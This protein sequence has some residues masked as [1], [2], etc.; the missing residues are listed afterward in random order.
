M[1][2]NSKLKLFLTRKSIICFWVLIFGLMLYLPKYLTFRTANSSI[3]ILVWPGILDLKLITEFEKSSGI[4]VNLS[5]FESNDELISKLRVTKGIGYD[6]I[7][8]SDYSV[9]R[10]IKNNILKPLD[11]TKLNFWSRL[12][13]ALLDHYFDP[14]NSFTVPIS[15]DILGLGINKN[16][17]IISDSENSSWKYVFD[18]KFIPASKIVISD[19]PLDVI[20]VAAIYLFGSPKDIDEQKLKHI[21]QLLIA[22]KPFVE[23]YTEYRPDYYLVTKNASIALESSIYIWRSLKDYPELDFLI[24]KE[25][26]L[27]I[28]EN[29]AIPKATNKDNLIYKFINYLLDPEVERKHFE[30]Y[31]LLPVT[32][33]IPEDRI[34]SPTIKRL[35]NLSKEDLS[36]FYFQSYD[37]FEKPI[38]EQQ[39]Q[40]LW[41]KIK[42]K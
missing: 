9:N 1:V 2:L 17:G 35:L 10:L 23:A 29:L 37:Y 18:P 11:K 5:Y 14:K 36:K 26:S 33:D 27:I 3:N 13:P 32:K 28:I 38:D 34:G 30:Q 16:L 25:G 42:T 41:I 12:N 19:D 31:T 24:P 22:Q 39:I 7:M 21:E 6:L 15:W 20:L 4:K 40:N 8:A